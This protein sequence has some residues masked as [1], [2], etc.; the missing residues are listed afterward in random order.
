MKKIYYVL[1]VLFLVLVAGILV[2][3]K[4]DTLFSENEWTIAQYGPRDINSSFYTIHNPRKGLIVI[5]GGWE[6]DA[7]YVRDVINIWGGKV[8]AWILTHPH[9]DHVGAFN[10]IY[11]DPGDIEIDEIYTVDMA[12]P[13]QC[14]EVASWDST[15]AYEDFL[16]LQVEDLQYVYPGDELKICGLDF[17][18][19]NAF[20]E[21][22]QEISK[23]YL[24]DGSMMFEVTNE[25]TSFLFCADVGKSMSEH[26]I[27]RWGDKLQADYLQMGHHGYGGLE[28][29]FYEKVCPSIAFFDAPDWMMYDGSGKF[30]NPQN[31]ALMEGMG[32][33]IVSFNQAPYFLILE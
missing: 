10:V 6:E 23:D 3:Q 4:R 5:D 8:D 2:Y 19:Y 24:N 21:T 32:C 11:S 14:L 9:Q 31:A 20:D 33:E 22:V 1:P 18:V 27:K 29:A 12:E 7:E 28:D 13:E 16:A 17:D 15:E 30:D 25:E 26:L